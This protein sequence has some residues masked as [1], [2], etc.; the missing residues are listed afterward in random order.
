VRPV[1][2]PVRVLRLIEYLIR[3]GADASTVLRNSLVGTLDMAWGQITASIVD[4]LDTNQEDRLQ[5]AKRQPGV[6]LANP[7]AMTGAGP[8]ENV[9]V[10]NKFEVGGFD[11]RRAPRASEDPLGRWESGVAPR[12]GTFSQDPEMITPDNG[13]E[14]SREVADNAN[15]LIAKFGYR[16]AY[17]L[18]LALSQIAPELDANA[19][20]EKFLRADEALAL[21]SALMDQIPKDWQGEIPPAVPATP[22][23]APLGGSNVD[24]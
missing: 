21:A 16:F 17:T 8:R 4:S 1:A 19:E 24:F 22:P 6:W 14:Y 13:P 12:P 2:Q 23:D 11:S 9:F 15:Y 7:E 3:P 5:L 20:P 10:G 18:A